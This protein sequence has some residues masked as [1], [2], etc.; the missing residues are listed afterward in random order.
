MTRAKE[1]QIQVSLGEDG[2]SDDLTTFFLSSN[3][4]GDK[5]RGK[6]RFAQNI[7]DEKRVLRS[8]HDGHMSC[9]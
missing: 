8:D 9:L 2:E 6:L 1:S 7:G 3:C 5:T 4:Y